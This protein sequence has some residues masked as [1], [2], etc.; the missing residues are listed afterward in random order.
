M[1]QRGAVLPLRL[2]HHGA[3]QRMGSKGEREWSEPLLL[4]LSLYHRHMS[5]S[6]MGINEEN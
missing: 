1:V 2:M 5:V 6:G 3:P 4:P